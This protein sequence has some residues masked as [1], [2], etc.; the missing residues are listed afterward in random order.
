MKLFRKRG[1]EFTVAK[2]VTI[3]IAMIFLVIAI[4]IIWDVK[5]KGFDILEAIKNLFVFGP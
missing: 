4:K 5:L 3:I 1:F 2:L